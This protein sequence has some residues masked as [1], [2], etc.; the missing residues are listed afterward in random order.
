[1]H[2]QGGVRDEGQRPNAGIDVA[3]AHL[4]V[5]AGDQKLQVGNDPSGWDELIA[6]LRALQVDLVV[7]EAT[8][9]YERGVVCAL[10]QAQL[11]VARVN[12]RQARD[13]AKSMGQLAKTDEVDARCLRDLA[14]VLARHQDRHKYITAA[15]QPHREQLVALMVRRR[16]LVEMRVAETNRLEGA[17]ARAVRSIRS[18]LKTLDRQLQDIDSDIDRHIDEHFKPQRQLLDS[19]KGVGPVTTLTMLSALPELGQLRRR[20]IAKLV[21]VAPLA[22]DS[23]K[24]RG[25]RRTWGGRAEVRAVLYMATLTAM[26]YNPAIKAFYERLVAA[27]KPKKVAIVACMRKLLT[28]LNAIMRDSATWNPL[29][30]MNGKGA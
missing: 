1:M 4:D 21:G 3:K 2:P 19:V 10:Q 15:A 25:V 11:C 13:F 9:G 17:N 23:G 18:V 28:I 26:R 30:S 12:P 20:Q 24:R 16:Q 7:V 27:G 22:D 5:C 8:G 14:D 6:K 29:A